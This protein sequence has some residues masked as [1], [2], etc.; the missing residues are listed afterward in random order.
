MY[1]FP[2]EFRGY[3]ANEPNKVNHRQQ[4]RHGEQFNA[5]LAPATLYLFES[6]TCCSLCFRGL[7]GGLT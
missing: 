4:L 1:R 6:L 2:G 5:S 3:Q 7:R